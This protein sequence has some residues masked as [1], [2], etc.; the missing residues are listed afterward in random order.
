MVNWRNLAWVIDFS[1][2]G[3]YIFIIF[4][5]MIASCNNDGEFDLG[6]NVEVI[7]DVQ[8]FNKVRINSGFIL[9]IT[10][11]SIQEVLLVSKETFIPNIAWYIKEG[12][13]YFE[14]ENK[15]KWLRKHNPTT[16]KIRTPVLE[17]IDNYG[18]GSLIRSI[19]TLRFNTLTVNSKSHSSEFEL[20]INNYNFNVV[21]ND[22]TTFKV[23]G[24]STIMDIFFAAS[25]CRF[26]GENFSVTD[27]TITHNSTNDMILTALKSL[28]GELQST[29]DVQYLQVPDSLA[30]T[31]LGRGQLI[32]SGN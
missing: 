32:Y 7:L 6:E 3:K 23:S 22:I 31:I 16:I 14:D 24:R 20:L 29:G 12:T 4:T 10:Q 13:L 18:S 19:D 21:C 28:T 30:V 8:P 26:E 11:D 2:M 15:F 5:F 9:E 1:V 17:R 25:D 27:I